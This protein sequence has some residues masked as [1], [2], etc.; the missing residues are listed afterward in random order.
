MGH[1]VFP[2]YSR[3]Y[4]HVNNPYKTNEKD[5]SLYNKDEKVE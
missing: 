5:L 1:S 2:L 4:K 3:K